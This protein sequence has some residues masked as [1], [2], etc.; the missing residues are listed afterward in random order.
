MT[1]RP[2]GFRQPD[3]IFARNLLGATPAE[4]VSPTSVRMRSLSR[5]AT[6]MPSDSPQAF[7]V[8]SR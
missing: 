2:S 5:F 3:A 7:S 1:V 6:V 8:T 4:A